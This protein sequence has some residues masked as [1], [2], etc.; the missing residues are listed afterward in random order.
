[1][2]AFASMEDIGDEDVEIIKNLMESNGVVN[3]FNFVREQKC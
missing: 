2:F 1:M 3:A